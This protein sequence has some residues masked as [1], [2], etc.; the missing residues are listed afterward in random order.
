MWFAETYEMG[1]IL[2]NLSVAK[3]G[4]NAM[5]VSE[6]YV[7]SIYEDIHYITLLIRVVKFAKN[8]DTVA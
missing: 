4:E 6:T 1:K 5:A 2:L 7:F 3:L 8:S